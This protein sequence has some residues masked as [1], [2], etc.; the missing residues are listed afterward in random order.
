[1]PHKVEHRPSIP[2]TP[3]ACIRQRSEGDADIGASSQLWLIHTSHSSV[4]CGSEELLLLR[5]LLHR[6]TQGGHKCLA[7]LCHCLLV[8]GSAARLRA[9]N[10]RRNCNLLEELSD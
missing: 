8:G 10:C 9:A 2:P 6:T 7:Q 5:P 1:M 3:A 4:D